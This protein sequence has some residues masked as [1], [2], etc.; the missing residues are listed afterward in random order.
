MLPFRRPPPILHLSQA[1]LSQRV[2][3][4]H[5]SPRRNGLLDVSHG[6]LVTLHNTGMPW[7]VVIP[8]A[9]ISIRLVLL[10]TCAAP[11]RRERARINEIMPL[12]SAKAV[13]VREE[14]E[15]DM[16]ENTH[17]LARK[18]PQDLYKEKVKKMGAELFDT[19]G[20]LKKLTML[21][22]MQIPVFIV[23][24]ETLRRMMGMRSTGAFRPSTPEHTQ[25][26]ATSTI[27]PDANAVSDP[28]NWYEPTMTFEGP[29]AIMDLTAA[30]PTLILP[31][32]VSGLWLANLRYTQ[33]KRVQEGSPRSR[34][35]KNLHNMLMGLGVIIFPATL[36]LPAG[37]LYYWA[38]TSASALGAD[39]IMDKI[40]PTS[41]S[42][43]P[44]RRPLPSIPI[45]KPRARI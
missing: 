10:A 2:R 11:A 42:V 17:L 21:P 14:T 45:K 5:A 26:D 38:C 22:L 20:V 29:F 36:H 8:V 34:F 18:S 24:S 28:S 41:P 1:H 19:W 32:A 23:M 6:F 16:L 27:T 33:H 13:Q 7:A 37:F 44:C 30:D 3:Q 9:A 25:S 31:L 12:I 35:Q 43:K 39:I 40:F 4:F 15:R